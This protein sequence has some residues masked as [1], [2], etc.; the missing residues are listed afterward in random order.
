MIYSKCGITTIE[1]TNIELLADL[2]VTVLSMLQSEIGEEDIKKAVE[3]AIQH[4]HV[5]P[6]KNIDLK[7]KGGG[8][9]W[10]S[11]KL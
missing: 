5:R 4:K 10:D 6:E 3:S 7:K 1:G 11:L 8:D 9:K 2:S